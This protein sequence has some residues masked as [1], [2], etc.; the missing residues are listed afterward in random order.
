MTRSRSLA[1]VAALSLTVALGACGSTE[2]GTTADAGSGSSATSA[3][4]AAAKHKVGDT[5]ELD[6][7]YPDIAAAMKAKKTYT[8]KGTAA[9]G[10][11]SAAIRTEGDTTAMKMDTTMEGKDTTVLLIDGVMYLG[12]MEGLEAGKKYLKVD[13]KGDDPMSKL[14]GPM[15]SQLTESM[16]PVAGLEQLDGLKAKVIEVD[17]GTTTYEMTVSV[18]QQEQMAKKQLEKMGMGDTKI[19]SSVEIK[20]LTIKQK[21]GADNLPISVEATGGTDG[22][23]SM[24]YADWGK[25]VDVQAP[26]ESEVGTFDMGELGTS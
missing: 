26:P 11:V 20:P 5:V 25:P 12:G 15:L 4:P 21:V 10:D 19:P 22:S 7:V 2:S 1:A 17:G 6:E 16:D 14:M 24:T 13:P 8:V 9:D 23:L 18:E 3:A